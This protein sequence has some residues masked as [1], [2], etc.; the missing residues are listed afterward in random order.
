M[1]FHCCNRF[2]FFTHRKTYIIF[3]FFFFFRALLWFIIENALMVLLSQAS[4]YLRHPGVEER[5]KS[6]LKRE[7]GSELVSSMALSSLQIV[8]TQV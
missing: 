3:F 5:Q 7:L 6:F 8:R 1:S 2:S 4:C